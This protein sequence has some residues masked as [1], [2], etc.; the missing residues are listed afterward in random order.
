MNYLIKLTAACLLTTLSITSYAQAVKTAINSEVTTNINFL[1]LESEKH[2]VPSEDYT[3]EEALKFAFN[4]QKTVMKDVDADGI[5]DAVVLLYYCEKTNCHPTTV[6]VDLVVF[7]GMGKSQFTKL[8]AAPL[9][10]SAKINSINKGVINITSY[11]YGENDAGCC[12]TDKTTTSYKIKNK[13]L[14]KVN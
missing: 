7:K 3:E 14:V 10:A 9:G 5:Q 2:F 12:P 4:N 6:S 11:S 13:K 8:G 1:N